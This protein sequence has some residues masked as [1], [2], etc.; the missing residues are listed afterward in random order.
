MSNNL[1]DSSS[2][3]LLQH[4]D[5]P[6]DWYPWSDEAFERAKEEDKPIFL[7]I[8]YSTCHWCHVMAHESFE[9]DEIAK[10]MNETFVNI[11]VDREERPDVDNV[12]MKV[13]Q[14]MTGGGGWPLTIIMTPDKRPFFAATYI[15]KES[16]MG[17]AGMEE[18]IPKIDQL[19]KEE[20]EK[21]ESSADKI[22][23]SLKEATHETGEDELDESV[24]DS[25]YR[26]MESK[27]D[28]HFGGFGK[29]PKF[30]S[31][32]N[33]LFLLRYASRTGEEQARSMV[34]S[35]LDH[36]RRGGIFDHIGYGF[37]RYSTDREWILPHFEKM[38]YDQAMLSRAYLE[39]YQITGKRKYAD[40]AEKVFEYV[41]REL[42][43]ENGG[44]YS[45]EDA[46]TEGEEG[47][48]YVWSMEELENV[49]TEDEMSFVVSVY[50]VQ[51]NGNFR[52]ESSGRRTGKN[53]LY[54]SSSHDE[55]METLEMDENT[56][57]ELRQSVRNKL[58]EK[59]RER[60]RPHLDD[61]ILT[62][63]NGLM[64]AS[65]AYGG[66][67]LDRSE[68]AEAA[69]GA[70]EFV[71]SHL[72]D[73]DDQLRHRY[74]NGD[75][76]VSG[77]ASDYAYFVRGLI[78]LHQTTQEPE[79]LREAV[80]LT[81]DFVER[82]YDGDE[83]GFFFT[84]TD[85]E[86][87]LERQKKVQD[88]ALPS[89]NSMA[90]WNLAQLSRLTGNTK[91][92]QVARDLAETFAGTVQQSPFSFTMFLSGLDVLLGPSKEVVVAG[93]SGEESVDRFLEV[94]N[95]NYLP[96]A[97]VLHRLTEEDEPA[98]CELAEFTREQGEVDG[99]TA[100]YVCTNF[101][102]EA[103]VTDPERMMKLIRDG[104]AGGN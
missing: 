15:P 44:F 70:V 78:E 3:Y 7:S 32:H 96:R 14:M 51:K 100:A 43:D 38:L 82:F 31:P 87:V 52:E 75:S 88:G 104:T 101:A 65:L 58:F 18:L 63:W 60:V 84:A 37:H 71:Q 12:Y 5:N 80:R 55:L 67:V 66:R 41:F 21:A 64:I 40:T 90:L 61:K 74:R 33:F 26:Q 25:A 57:R 53:I 76:A 19:W 24:F 89:S 49:L 8:G 35:T 42:Q 94:L 28:T 85:E 92:Q 98:I 4:A 16:G 30:P 2:P 39:G 10:M 54:R 81:E 93:P 34:E 86:P 45:A 9:D 102:C 6:V 36:M 97:V 59:R 13:C 1:T 17:R 27:F 99:E 68:Y 103:P 48:F 46:D 62:D 29:E 47:K 22:V 83:G 20:R 50:N 56:Y 23:S 72:Y 69:A 11:K 91:F 73:E 79:Y 95:D 77:N